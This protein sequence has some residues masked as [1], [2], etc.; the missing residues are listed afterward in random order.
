MATGKT[1]KDIF[2]RTSKPDIA[3]EVAPRIMGRPKAAEAYQKVTVCLFNRQTIWLDKV[4][5]A[6]R[7]KTGQNVHRAELVRAGRLRRRIN[8]K[9]RYLTRSTG[10]RRALTWSRIRWPG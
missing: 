10:P 2:K 7:E 4:R 3:L 9:R 8:L 6:I 5:L 1:S